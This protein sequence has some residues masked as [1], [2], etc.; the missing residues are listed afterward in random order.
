VLHAAQD[1]AVKWDLVPRNVCD[2]VEAPLVPESE[3]ESLTHEEAGKLLNA[4]KGDRLEALFVTAI[5]SGCRLG[6][7]LALEWS[8][9]DLIAGILSVTKSQQELNGVLKIK[10]PKTKK[11]RGKID[12]PDYATVALIEHRKRML[13]EGNAAAERVF[14]N[15]HGGAL[16]RSHFHRQSWKPLLKR[17]ELPHFHFHS[18]RHTN[19]SLSLAAGVPVRDVSERAGHAKASMTLDRYGHCLPGAGRFAAGKLDAVL[20]AAA[21]AN[22]KPVATVG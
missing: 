10:P 6:E 9:V 14:C 13:I 12:L 7:L 15:Q 5:A 11:S 19:I 16:R 18:L 21:T 8:D 22:A 3:V 4:V 20:T 17:A 2:A 1:Q